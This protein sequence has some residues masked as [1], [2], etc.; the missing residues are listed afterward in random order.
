MKLAVVNGH[1]LLAVKEGSDDLYL[2]YQPAYKKGDAVVV[3]RPC[4]VDT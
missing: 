4:Q 3:I 2:V 1:R